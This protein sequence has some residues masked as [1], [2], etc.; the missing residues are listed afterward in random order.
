MA[1][2]SK[3]WERTGINHQNEYGDGSNFMSSG[4]PLTTTSLPNNGGIQPLSAQPPPI[5]ARPS[6][7]PMASSFN[8]FGYGSGYGGG[9]GYGG[10]GGYGM[11]SSPYS[12]YGGYGTGYGGMNRYGMSGEPI[13]GFARQAE[14]NSR[15]AFESIESIVNAFTSVSMMLDSSFQAVYSSF[16]A[17]IGV[18]DNFSRL[19]IQLMQVFSALAF[20]R[21]L[22]YV[23]RR[24]LEFLRLRPQGTAVAEW[25]RAFAAAAQSASAA[26]PEARK[27]SW[28]IL[29]FF[30]IILGGPWLIWKLIS[31]FAG[32][33][34]SGIPQWADGQN[35]HFVADVLFDFT[36]QSTEEVSVQAGQKIN[37]A[38]KELQ[39]RVRGWLLASNDGKT[40]LIPANYVKVLGKRRGS[41]SMAQVNNQQQ[42]NVTNGNPVANG[43]PVVPTESALNLVQRQETITESEMESSF[44]DVNTFENSTPTEILNQSDSLVS[45]SNTKQDNDDSNVERVS[46]KS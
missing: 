34:S 1:S 44:A 7:T 31:S 25:N 46:E 30:G 43:N 8:R 11:Y 37:V 32:V 3:P 4:P 33:S 27:T 22:K 20:I 14:E 24:I 15:P 16:R 6:A 9:M 19:K 36:A 38:P 2:P 40:G 35:D 29:M 10:V 23:F 41:K 39:P 18:A 28:P 13:G 5:P 42:T 21:T 17:V 45:D 12:S 26:E